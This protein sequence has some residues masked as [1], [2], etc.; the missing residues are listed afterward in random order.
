MIIYTTLKQIIREKWL[1]RK[2]ANGMVGTKIFIIKN[3]AETKEYYVCIDDIILFILSNVGN[4]FK[5]NRNLDNLKWTKQSKSVQKVKKF[6]P[7]G[8]PKLD[9]MLDSW[10]VKKWF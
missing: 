9:T 2:R 5:I 1:T 3:Y 6:P 4:I 10:L 8:N 7:R